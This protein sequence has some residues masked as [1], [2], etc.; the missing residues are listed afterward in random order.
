MKFP[1]GTK[2]LRV[3]VLL[4]SVILL[5][6]ACAPAPP[7]PP[8]APQVASCSDTGN[9]AQTLAS[10]HLKVHPYT[11]DQGAMNGAQNSVNRFANSNCSTPLTHAPIPGWSENLYCQDFVSGCP[12]DS[13]G[14]VKALNG[15]LNSPPHRATIDNT[16]GGSLGVGTICVAGRYFFAAAEYHG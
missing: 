7:P 1:T 11:I 9:A 6:A 2:T 13:F 12:S 5:A 14:A 4:G 10:C 8:P 3:G 16:S 15:W